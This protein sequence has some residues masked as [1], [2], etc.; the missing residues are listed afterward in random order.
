MWIESYLIARYHAVGKKIFF[1]RFFFFKFEYTSREKKKLQNF[2]TET[3][4]LLIA[5]ICY[6]GFISCWF[7]VVTFKFCL[8]YENLIFFYEFYAVW[9]QVFLLINFIDWYWS[10]K[11]LFMHYQIIQS[12]IFNYIQSH[13]S[14]KISKSRCIYFNYIFWSL[15]V[16]ITLGCKFNRNSEDWT[17]VSRTKIKFL[18][19]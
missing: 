6:G 3:I 8:I 7:F 12:L 11:K 1:L 17:W 14:F 4:R 13:S 18:K 16:L 10:I 2:L 9:V 15:I 19:I 5:L